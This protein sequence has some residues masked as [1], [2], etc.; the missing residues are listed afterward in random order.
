MYNLLGQAGRKVRQEE[1]LALQEEQKNRQ[2]CRLLPGQ[3]NKQKLG[4]PHVHLSVPMVLPSTSADWNE[5]D[6]EEWCRTHV[7]DWHSGRKII[8]PNDQHL[9]TTATNDDDKM[10]NYANKAGKQLYRVPQRR[11]K[12]DNTY[13]RDDLNLAASLRRN[14]AATA[15]AAAAATALPASWD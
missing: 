5:K 4:R 3:E 9:V 1:L 14:T 11:M 2:A 15:A 7:P 6:S 13:A 12:S 10:T 8:N